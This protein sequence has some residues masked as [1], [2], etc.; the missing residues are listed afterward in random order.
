MPHAAASM[1]D[2]SKWFG[3]IFAGIDDLRPV[4]HVKIFLLAPFLDGK[5]L[6]VNVPSTGCGVPFVDHMRSG[7]IISEQACWARS[8]SIKCH[9][10]AVKTLDDLLTGH[11]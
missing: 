8:K 7:H 6:D 10:D 1:W 2:P 5:M 3:E 11:G 4:F 9:E